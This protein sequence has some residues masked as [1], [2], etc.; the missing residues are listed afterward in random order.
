[1]R[2]RAD[3]LSG[4]HAHRSAPTGLLL[5]AARPSPLRRSGG[6][7]GCFATLT[8]GFA[9]GSPPAAVKTAACPKTKSAKAD[10]IKRSRRSRLALL[11][12]GDF[13]PRRPLQGAARP[14]QGA[15]R[16]LQGAARP[17][18]FMP[19]RT[20]NLE[21]IPAPGTWNESPHLERASPP[22]P[23]TQNLKPHPET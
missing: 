14:L 16:P 17:L 21:R 1:M 18:R 20:W 22:K 19:R 12:A 2:H 23:K 15:A 10:S 7:T 6:S 8:G 9:A 5:S 11:L 3:S 13:N 4:P